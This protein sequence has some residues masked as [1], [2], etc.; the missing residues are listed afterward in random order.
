VHRSVF[1]KLN[2]APLARKRIAGFFLEAIQMFR[3]RLPM[4]QRLAEHL[5]EVTQLETRITSLG[6]T[7]RGGVPTPTDR[8][9]ATKYGTQAAEMILAGEFG[10]MVAKRGHDYVSV[11]IEDVAGK[12]RYVPMDHA[13]VSAARLVGTCL[14]DEMPHGY[15]ESQRDPAK[16]TV[17]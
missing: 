13:W 10:C 5:E 12:R 6:H 4:S 11:P 3:W 17:S 16:E 7:Q 8:L 2:N 9:L 15:K 14:G 1:D